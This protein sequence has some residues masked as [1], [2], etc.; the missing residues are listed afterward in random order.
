MEFGEL[1]CVEARIRMTIM[2]MDF[3]ACESEGVNVREDMKTRWNFCSAK[4]ERV[5]T[6]LRMK[7]VVDFS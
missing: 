2:V 3:S 1:E 4:V 7:S 5:E 6:T